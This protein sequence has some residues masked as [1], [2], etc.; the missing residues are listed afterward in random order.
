MPDIDVYIDSKIASGNNWQSFVPTMFEISPLLS[1][2]ENIVDDF[3]M[4]S[5]LSGANSVQVEAPFD[6][7][8]YL[9]VNDSNILFTTD[10]GE[11]WYRDTTITNEIGIVADVE[12]VIDELE[13][14]SGNS[15]RE[16]IVLSADPTPVPTSIDLSVTA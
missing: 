16:T 2:T 5:T 3:T 10:A 4:G 9:N 1:G 11:S 7:P 14:W 15:L 13:D 8:G 12:F 6:S